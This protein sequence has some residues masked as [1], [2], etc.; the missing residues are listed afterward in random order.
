VSPP[1][2][3]VLRR[4]PLHKLNTLFLH[5]AGGIGPDPEALAPL[6]G[7]ADSWG[8]ARARGTLEG[9]TFAPEG[10]SQ[11]VGLEPRA[12]A[13][14]LAAEP[15]EVVPR[16]HA[17]QLEMA[18]ALLG[19]AR[20]QS[21][22]E[23]ARVSDARGRTAL[24][25][26]AAVGNVPLLELLL[27]R[28]SAVETQDDLGRSAAH[29]AALYGQDLAGECLGSAASAS[30][31]SGSSAMRDIDGRTASDI[32]HAKALPFQALSGLFAAHQRPKEVLQPPAA[33]EGWRPAAADAAVALGLR[34]TLPEDVRLGVV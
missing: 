18:G 29:L 11:L 32:V 28:G 26:A 19:S 24:H 12:L 1:L 25:Y 22:S 20:A 21:S 31:S 17:W 30:S 3:E 23:A 7:G 34:A 27:H 2:V 9:H 6:R 16:W 33:A 4:R 10:S 5:V 15:Q 13:A 14:A 8:R